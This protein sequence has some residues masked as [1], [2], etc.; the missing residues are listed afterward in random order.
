MDRA[1]LV[2][3][4]QKGLEYMHLCVLIARHQMSRGRYFWFEQPDRA[5][6][7]ELDSV[8]ELMTL[9]GVLT[10]RTDQ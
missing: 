10:R 2:E 5:S 6:S 3:E 1:K 4:E 9:P 7:L 8:K